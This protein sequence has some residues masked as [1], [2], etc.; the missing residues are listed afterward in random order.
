MMFE[1]VE[2]ILQL[3]KDRP[4]ILVTPMPR[5]LYR[6]CCQDEEHAPNRREEGFEENLRR[7]LKNFKISLKNLCF[8]RNLRLRIID[9]SP[10]LTQHSEDGEE[11]WGDDPVHPRDLGYAR[12]VDLLE[13][14]LADKARA[15]QKRAGDSTGRP[16]KKPRLEVRPD[17]IEA[18]SE[19][20]VRRENPPQRGRGGS[21]WMRGG[22]R[23][24]PGRGGPSGPSRGSGRGGRGGSEWQNK[25]WF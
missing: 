23:G 18:G 25:S 21:R 20:A 10:R 5:W 24:R 9:P 3:V 12:I 22:Q 6:G 4:A 15:G 19:T 17:W 7:D 2:P 8:T 1:T 13:E 16:N 14:Q 11:I